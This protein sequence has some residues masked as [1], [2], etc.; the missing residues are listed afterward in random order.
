MLVD[1]LLDMYQK[2]KKQHTKVNSHM[3][4]DSASP[5]PSPVPQVL[6]QPDYLRKVVDEMREHRM[7]MVANY[8]QYQFCYQAILIGC[9][10]IEAQDL[11]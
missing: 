10:R 6:D 2:A 5:L 9:Q 11:H 4:V 7:S 1:V 3:D 8:A